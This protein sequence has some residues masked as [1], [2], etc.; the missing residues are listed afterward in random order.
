MIE[1]YAIL[2]YVSLTTGKPVVTVYNDIECR[3]YFYLVDTWTPANPSNHIHD[4]FLEGRDLAG[5]LLAI[6]GFSHGY[7]HTSDQ[8]VLTKINELPKVKLNF[9]GFKWIKLAN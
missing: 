6:Q 1:N 2:L 7:D 8:A 3:W 9:N 4:N 5:L